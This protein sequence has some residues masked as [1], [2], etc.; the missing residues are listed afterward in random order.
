MQLESMPRSC[1]LVENSVFPKQEP[2]QEAV[3]IIYSVT[4]SLSLTFSF[5]MSTEEEEYDEPKNS[6]REERAKDAN[7]N[8]TKTQKTSYEYLI[9]P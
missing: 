6:E 3:K 9:F 7:M 2:K 8:W 4:I 1:N 5:C